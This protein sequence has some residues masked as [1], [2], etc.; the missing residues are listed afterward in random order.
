MALGL[1]NDYY[2]LNTWQGLLVKLTVGQKTRLSLFKKIA[3]YISD[4][5]DL[6]RAISEMAEEY[7][8]NDKNDGRGLIL[9]EWNAAMTDAAEDFSTAISDWVGSTDAMMVKAGEQGGD[10]V[11]ALHNV[12]EANESQSIIVS[13]VKGALTYPAVL[14]LLTLMMMF[15]TK[16]KI[17]PAFESMIDPTDW[18]EGPAAFRYWTLFFTGNLA[19]LITGFFASIYAINWSMANFT[20]PIRDKFLDRIPPWSAYKRVN[21][22]LFLISLSAMMDTGTAAFDAIKIL[23]D[24]SSKYIQGKLDYI[25]DKMSNG[26]DLSVALDKNFFDDE[27]MMDIRLYTKGNVSTEGMVEIGKASIESTIKNISGLS[28]TARFIMM[29]VAGGYMIWMVVSSQAVTSAL[30]ASIGV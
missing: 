19:V 22:S 20:G 4:G 1:N 6:Q 23:R 18:P 3:K 5:I 21:A 27:T 11:K 25:L 13:T 2:Y 28:N 17:L 8:N 29:G 7:L 14:M 9:A 10:L 26:E 30:R 16:S 12:I 15:L 24:Y